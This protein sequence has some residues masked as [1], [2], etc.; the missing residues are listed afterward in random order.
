[1]GGIGKRFL[2]KGY[3]TYKS[4]LPINKTT[5]FEN[6]ISNF[7]YINTEV[8]LIANF[9]ALDSE[10]QTYYKKKG[11]H[12]I[13]INNHKFG[14]LYSI[15]LAFDKIK[16][17]IKQD[18]NIFISYSDINWSWDFKLVKKFFLKQEAIIFT[19]SG[20]HPHIE[21]DCKSDFCEKKNNK[22]NKILEKDTI[23][24]DYKK[25]LLAI[26]CY[27]FKNLSYLN[28]FFKE[29][30]IF[31]KKKEYYI[32]SLIKYLIK[33]KVNIK[34]FNLKKFVHL[35]TPEQYEDFLNW[36]NFFY[37]ESL[38]K[39]FSFKTF[40]SIM[41]MGGK[42]KR[43]SEIK[44]PKPLLPVKNKPIYK[45]IFKKLNA[46]KKII[47]INDKF[48]RH[49]DNKQ[50]KIFQIKKTNSLFQTISL[51]KNLLLSKS[52]FFL[53]SCDCF[54]VFDRK[55]LAKKIN[56]KK[57]DI[58][59]FAFKY[60]NL[61]KNLDNSHTQ[62]KIKRKK[63]YDIKVKEK[64]N[65][66]NLGHAGFFW[67][68]KGDVFSHLLKFQSSNYYKTINREIIIDDYFKFLIKKKL[69]TSSYVVLNHYI[70]IGS[71]KEYLEYK[72]W[73]NYFKNYK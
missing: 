69:I 67:I 62:L 3:K 24:N 55:E 1:M 10:Y 65:N 14:P 51:S 6:I 29:S 7:K 70:H 63:L 61:Q 20:F 50:F 30:K 45:Y 73:E 21:V 2:K 8:I 52:N 58:I 44:T 66:S 32:V 11:F 33:R 68:R 27:Y 22:I 15:F 23:S 17:I 35:G 12:L 54:G 40:T 37:K 71:T 46:P 43:V 34:N 49:I 59:F 19:H 13:N 60:S 47:I 18:K 41:L 53:T 64:Y 9:K 39:K 48:K 4:F 42:G 72:Y 36:K 57:V 5:I 28:L 31:K 56:N 25:D 26:G 38:N 16:N